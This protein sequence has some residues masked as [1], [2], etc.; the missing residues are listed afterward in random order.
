M[1]RRNFIKTGSLGL[2]ASIFTSP[3]SNLRATG[4]S[5]VMKNWVWFHLYRDMN[6]DR[7]YEPFRHMRDAGI[8]GI[9]P[10]VYSSTRAHFLSGHLPA[11]R[12]LLNEILPVARETGLEVHAWMWTMICNIRD[13][14]E[15]HPEWFVVN[16]KG[17]SCLEKPAYVGYY[18]FLCPNRPGAREFLRMTVADLSAYEDLDGVHLDYIRYPDVIL[19]ENL[20]KKYGI[21][22]DREYPEYDYCYCDTCRSL[23]KEESGIDPITLEQ[24]H[25]NQDWIR[26]RYDSITNLVN[27]VLVAEA[28]K[29]TKKITAAVFPNWQHVR[30]QWSRWNLD[31]FFPMLY[32]RYYN[33]DLDWIA[34]KTKTGVAELGAGKPLYSGLMVDMIDEGQMEKV[35]KMCRDAGASGVS[36][37]SYSRMKEKKWQAFSEGQKI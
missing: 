19:A 15:Q 21:V 26:F 7:L 6:R 30:Q 35:V 11:G 28:R 3:F 1:I 29:K 14:H 18:R 17:E 31:G 9:L 23:F 32:H 8:H 22:Q 2:A 33:E 10:E 20:Q 5:R 4:Q 37:F 12:D 24:P 16:R 34:E 27:N 13:I 36:L 25:L